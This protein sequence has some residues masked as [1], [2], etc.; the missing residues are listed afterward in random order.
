MGGEFTIY[1]YLVWNEIPTV[2]GNLFGGL[3]LV[4]IPLYWTHVKTGAERKL[5]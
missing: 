3:C 5:S 4:G 1:D 2:L